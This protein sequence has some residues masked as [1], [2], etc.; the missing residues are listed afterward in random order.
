MSKGCR[1]GIN[2]KCVFSVY[3]MGVTSANRPFRIANAIDLP[4]FQKNTFGLKLSWPV[5]PAPC[6]HM[7]GHMEML[8]AFVMYLNIDNPVLI[9]F[10]YFFVQQK[11][12]FKLV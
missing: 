12:L 2:P 10:S 8:I 6:H 7:P 4:H 3:S 1:N 11:T 5:V 9:S